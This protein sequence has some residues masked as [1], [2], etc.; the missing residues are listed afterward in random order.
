MIKIIEEKQVPR[1]QITCRSC[2]CTSPIGLLMENR[3][4]PMTTEMQL[5]QHTKWSAG[6]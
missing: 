6:Y 4:S 5:P 1:A 3:T 2:V